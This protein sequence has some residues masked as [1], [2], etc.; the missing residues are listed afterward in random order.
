MVLFIRDGAQRLQTG[1][2]HL[3]S[4]IPMM[5][6]PSQ[7]LATARLVADARHV[8]TSKCS[9]RPESSTTTNGATVD[10]AVRDPRECTTS[11]PAE[12]RRSKTPT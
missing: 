11:Q 2:D 5:A 9:L 10:P 3:E 1:H 8:A 12:G 6:S 7:R 4:A